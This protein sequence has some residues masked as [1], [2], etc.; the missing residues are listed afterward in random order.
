MRSELEALR[1]EHQLLKR[2]LIL[3]EPS[4]KA[5]DTLARLE[6]EIEKKQAQVF[7]AEIEALRERQRKE[8]EKPC[9]PDGAEGLRAELREL[10][11]Q[12]IEDELADEIGGSPRQRGDFSF[13]YPQAAITRLFIFEEKMSAYLKLIGGDSVYTAPEVEGLREKARL[14]IS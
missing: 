12:L 3:I 11:A 1:A 7:A 4:E 10:G 13:R 14:C 6:S 5:C 8:I 9:E 2:R